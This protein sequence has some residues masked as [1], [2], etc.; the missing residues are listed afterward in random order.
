MIRGAHAVASA[1][2]QV[3]DDMNALVTPGIGREEAAEESSGSESTVHVA[4]LIRQGRTGVGGLGN[5]MVVRVGGSTDS[6]ADDAD[7]ADEVKVGEASRKF[8]VAPSY[9]FHSN[10][11]RRRWGDILSSHARVKEVACSAGVPVKAEAVAEAVAEEV[12]I[13]AEVTTEA[14]VEAVVEVAAQVAVDMVRETVECGGGVSARQ[15]AA[16]MV[17]SVTTTHRGMSNSLM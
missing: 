6:N 9:M 8:R 13:T 16:D 15:R 12:K 10:C 4:E 7:E 5:V 3:D 2:E 1:A 17:C 11:L 14:P